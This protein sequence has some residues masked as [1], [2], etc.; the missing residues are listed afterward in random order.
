M[1]LA[2]RR[3]RTGSLTIYWLSLM[4]TALTPILSATPLDFAFVETT[5]P[6]LFWKLEP[7]MPSTRASPPTAPPILCSGYS[8]RI[9]AMGKH[10]LKLQQE[11]CR[12]NAAHAIGL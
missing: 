7:P 11:Y 4:S 1:V 8:T 12:G 2:D 10:L 6:S 9:E 3:R 5:T